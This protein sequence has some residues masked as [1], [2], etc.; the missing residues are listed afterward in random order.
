MKQKELEKEIRLWSKEILETPNEH[1]FPTCP[2]AKKTWDANKVKVIISDNIYWDDLFRL[3]LGFPEN[4]DVLI[5]CDFDYEMPVEI[6][7]DRVRTFNM[8]LNRS[9]L[10]IMGFH[11]E[12]AEKEEVSQDNF[13]PI[14]DEIYNMVF[15]QRLKELNKASVNLEKIGYYKSWTKSEMEN[16]YNRR[17][18]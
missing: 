14:N 6:F 17:N 4:I 11:Q 12:H 7:D 16:I 13:V 2:Y 10:W 8:L 15:V 5:Y 18:K 1:N 3:C 9:N